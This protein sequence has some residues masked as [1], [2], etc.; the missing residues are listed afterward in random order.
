MTKIAFIGAGSTVFVKK[1][2]GDVLLMPELG[3]LDIA[4]MDIDEARLS[5]SE[6]VANKIAKSVGSSASISATTDRPTALDGADFVIVMIQVGG[7][8]P[9][10]VI[11]FDVP[12]SIGL[13]QTIADTLGA[14]GIMRGLRTVPV[15]LDI[16]NDMRRYCPDALMLQYVNPMAI[17]CWALSRLAPDIKVVGLC[18]SVQKTSA[19][20]AEHLGKDIADIRFECAGINHMAF[21]TRFEE[22]VGGDYSDLYPQMK[23]FANS[24]AVP[25]DERVRYDILRR[26]GFFVTESSE[27]FAEYVPWYIKSKS[28]QL[29][30][31][32]NI[33]LNDYPRRC[34]EQIARWATMEK[35]L[36]AADKIDVTQSEEYAGQ[37]IRA[38]VTGE[39]VVIHGNVPNHDLIDNLPAGC[40]VEVPCLVDRNGVQ[41]V[42]V[43]ALP[44]HLAAMM[45]TNVAPQTCAVEALVTGEREHIYRALA[46]DPHTGAELSLEQIWSLTDQLLQAHDGYLPHGWSNGEAAG[47][48]APNMVGLAVNA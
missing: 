47:N 33:P 19:M 41:P 32:F 14:G 15:L 24:N 48:S 12:D 22:R 43:G 7:Y 11:D 40:C 34:E 25:D 35:D 42:R 46:L 9:S 44:N 28:P 17:N 23:A 31:E 16:A 30:E 8:R 4:L 2:L 10:T 27:H 18:H 5:T 37:I 38:S 45:L 39:P 29:I 21:F 13:R 20:L 26:F 3:K 1:I 6:M 36:K